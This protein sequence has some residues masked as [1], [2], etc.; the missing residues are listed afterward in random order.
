MSRLKCRVALSV[1]FGSFDG[2]DYKDGVC[3]LI[4]LDR[5]RTLDSQ[6]KGLIE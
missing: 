5:P 1:A 6:K 4:L 2:T 3:L